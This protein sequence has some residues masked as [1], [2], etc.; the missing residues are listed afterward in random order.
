MDD[1]ER[2]RIPDPDDA[3][4]REGNAD[5]G[6]GFAIVNPIQEVSE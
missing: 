1:L 3:C 4:L 6:N 2:K 5:A